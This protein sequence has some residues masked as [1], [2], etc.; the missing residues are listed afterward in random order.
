MAKKLVRSA[1]VVLALAGFCGTAHAI[2]L[3]VGE[4]ARVDYAPGSDGAGTPPFAFIKLG[5]NFS[6][7]DPFG[8]NESLSYQVYAQDGT[9]LGGGVASAGSSE[10]TSGLLGALTESV[11]PSPALASTSFY[12]TVTSTGGSFDLLG[13]QADLYNFAGG[14]SQ[15]GSVGTVAAAVPEPSTWAMMLLGFTGVGAAL[16]W[17]RHRKCE[18]VPTVAGI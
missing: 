7:A 2:V 16:H 17:R 8:P 10:Y 9:P 12:A 15:F 11:F 18:R 3:N 1:F 6:N 4:T 5:F 14:A 13:G